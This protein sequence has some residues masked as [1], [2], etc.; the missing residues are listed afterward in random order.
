MIITILLV[1]IV[2]VCI[3]SCVSV[4]HFFEF[5][6][7]ELDYKKIED[8]YAQKTIKERTQYDIEQERTKQR[9]AEKEKEAETTKQLEIKANYEKETGNKLY[10]Y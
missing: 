2:S 4:K 1:L 8:E 5:K 7:K 9:I 6:I 10:K 3:V